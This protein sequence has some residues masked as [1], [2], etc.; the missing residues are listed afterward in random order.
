M[1]NEGKGWLTS[2]NLKTIIIHNTEKNTNTWTKR[3]IQLYHT[4]VL[5]SPYA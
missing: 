4:A 5:L 3:L 1:E 2:L